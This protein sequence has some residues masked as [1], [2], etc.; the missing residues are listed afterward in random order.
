MDWVSSL[1]PP[2]TTRIS[3]STSGWA[4]RH[5]RQSLMRAVSLRT[6]T[7]MLTRSDRGAAAASILT[8]PALR[9]RRRTT[10][11]ARMICSAPKIQK[12]MSGSGEIFYLELESVFR[13]DSQLEPVG[14]GLIE[15]RLPFGSG[16]I[17]GER[18]RKLGLAPRTRCS[19]LR[20]SIPPSILPGA[21]TLPLRTDWPRC[22]T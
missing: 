2:S 13:S 15:K 1:E 16:S 19:K 22:T 18:L 4:M 7:I 14:T 21:M 12:Y 20:T 10:R 17:S 8:P 9:A 11:R 5:S 6:G 3:A